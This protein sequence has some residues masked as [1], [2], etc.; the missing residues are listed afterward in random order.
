MNVDPVDP[1]LASLYDAGASGLGAD[2]LE[3]LARRAGLE[4]QEVPG[5][6]A[7][8]GMGVEPRPEGGLRLVEPIKLDAMLIERGLG[9]DRIGQSAICFQ[10]VGSTNDVA[11]D[12]A[13]QGNTDGLVIAAESQQSGRGR[14]GRSWLSPPGRNL[15]FSVVLHDPQDK[16]AQEA[17]TI[18]AGL[19]VAE[20]LEQVTGVECELKWPNDVLVDQAKLAG[21]LV[22]T[23]RIRRK[24]WW[25]MGIGINVGAVPP[26]EQIH[27]RGACLEDLCSGP[28]DRI[29]IL[30]QVLRRLE[31]WVRRIEARS[32]ESLRRAWV[33]RCGMLHGRIRARQGDREY[34]GIVLDIHPMEGLVLGLDRGPR[35]LLASANTTILD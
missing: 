15:L 27:A 5:L 2:A 11:W 8:R 22:E 16:L 1:I 23:G 9:T 10:S 24:R 13:R 3:G 14:F 25:V 7:Q 4:I 18:S 33:A 26:P 6:L 28:C 21:V 34:E 20:A 19:A 29:A 35:V 30:R 31:C 17:L 12:S 32:L